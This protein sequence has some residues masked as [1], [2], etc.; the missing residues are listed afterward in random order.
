MTVTGAEGYVRWGYR[1][2]VLLRAWTIT[3]DEHGI[4]SL[5][6]TVSDVDDFAVSQRPLKFAAPNG[7]RWPVVSESL[8]M[9]GASLTAVLG[10]KE[11]SHEQMSF[12]S[13]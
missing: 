6:G 2:A 12:R 9:T 1:Q 4:L 10:P 13:A 5:T 8:Q 3:K 7:W 11:S